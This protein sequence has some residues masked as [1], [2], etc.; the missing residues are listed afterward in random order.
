MSVSLEVIYEILGGT[1]ETK[2]FR[3]FQSALAKPQ[4]AQEEQTGDIQLLV[5]VDL[6]PATGQGT[7]SNGQA[8]HRRPLQPPP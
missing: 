7:S 6:F 5:R 4:A 3:T 1:P 8:T 2:D